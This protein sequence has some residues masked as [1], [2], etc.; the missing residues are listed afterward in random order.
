MSKQ[1]L[2]AI[3]IDDEAHCRSSLRKQIEWSCPEIEVL[4]EGNDLASGIDCIKEH[5]PSI[6]FLDIAM[7]GGSGFDLLQQIDKIDFSI[8]FTTAYDEYALQAFKVNALAYLLK[9]RFSMS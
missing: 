8:I 6:V 1:K 5:Q 4:G 9:A 2:T 7:P 3:I